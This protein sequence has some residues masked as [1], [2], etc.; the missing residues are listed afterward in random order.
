M[1]LTKYLLILCMLIATGCCSASKN[2]S[3]PVGKDA[4][5]DSIYAVGVVFGSICC[6]TASDEF[7]KEFISA[8]NNKNSIEINADIAAGCGREGEFVILINIPENK[9]TIS[10]AFI[11]E[12]EKIVLER[13]AKNKQSNSS[14]GGIE[15]IKDRK[16]SDYLHC[17]LGIKKWLM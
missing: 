3:S 11:T 4:H 16:K 8:Y 2:N 5:Q 7:L 14:S 10:A 6:G 1:N 9:K 17:R 12:L 15:V 13:D